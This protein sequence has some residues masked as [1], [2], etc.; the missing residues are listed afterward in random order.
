M[1]CQ[2]I[3]T[4]AF[5]SSKHILCVLSPEICHIDGKLS[6]CHIQSETMVTVIKEWRE[7]GYTLGMDFP[8]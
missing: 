2:Y 4:G 5:W 7:E 8:S 1:V 6:L 3:W